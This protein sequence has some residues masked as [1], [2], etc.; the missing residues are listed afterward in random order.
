MTVP[1]GIRNALAVSSVDQSKYSLAT[2]TTRCLTGNRVNAA[3]TSGSGS[4]SV[5]EG[6]TSISTASLLVLRFHE[7]D[8]FT[9]TR[10]TQ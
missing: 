5:A 3:E 10:N 8:Q 6:S 9:A 7:V 4:L 2:T 1:T